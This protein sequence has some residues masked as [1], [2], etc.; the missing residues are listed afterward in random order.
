MAAAPRFAGKVLF[1]TGGASGL[2]AAT[3]RRFSTEGGRVAVVDLDGDRAEAVASELEG[4]LGLACDVSDEESVDEA[5]RAVQD[6]LGRL[7]C[8]LNAAGFAQFTP[9][10][11]LSLGDWNKNVFAVGVPMVSN[12]GK[13][14]AFSCFGPV[15]DMTRARLVSD[16]GPR[17]VELR[18]RVKNALG[19]RF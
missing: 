15:H 1:A 14:F 6:R 18:D 3:A 19:G 2:A 10:E 9:I 11:E 17:L 5:V 16:I 8:V 7:D 4:S 13:V 12:E